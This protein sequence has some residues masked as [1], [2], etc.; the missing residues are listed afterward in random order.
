MVLG[1]LGRVGRRLPG[2]LCGAGRYSRLLGIDPLVGD[3]A[4][5]YF[6][7]IKESQG[8]ANLMYGDARVSLRKAPAGHYE[9][10]VVDVFN[11]GST[12]ST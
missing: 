5:K 6:T 9:A 3:I 10:M 11:S 2:C 8:Q 1:S 12:L 7:F 4:Q